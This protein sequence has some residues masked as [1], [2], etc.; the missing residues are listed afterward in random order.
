MLLQ[1]KESEDC[2]N[3]TCKSGRYILGEKSEIK[4]RAESD[5]K[6]KQE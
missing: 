5:E 1:Q 2:E 4:E 6:K 3:W